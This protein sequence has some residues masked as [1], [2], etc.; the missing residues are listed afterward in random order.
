MSDPRIE[1]F[2]KILVEHSA[3]VQPG[4][5]VEIQTTLAALPL[6]KEIYNKVLEYP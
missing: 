5:R 6:V 1:N 4:D 2:A 3:N